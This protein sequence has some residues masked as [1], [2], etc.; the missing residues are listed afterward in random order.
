VVLD[1]RVEHMIAICLANLDAPTNWEQD[2]VHEVAE[3][4][5]PLS[6]KQL[7]LLKRL[8]AN[9]RGSYGGRAYAA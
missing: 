7:R 1:L 6:Q 9:A 5:G 3:W 4:R 2:L 8:A